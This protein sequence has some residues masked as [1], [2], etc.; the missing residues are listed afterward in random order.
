[1]WSSWAKQGQIETWC[2]LSVGAFCP[3][4]R[5]WKCLMFSGRS[6]KCCWLFPHLTVCSHTRPN[7][8]S[9]TTA[10]LFCSQ[11]P[12]LLSQPPLFFFLRVPKASLGG[13]GISSSIPQVSVPPPLP[14][15]SHT[16]CFL[17]APLFLSADSS[18]SCG[19]SCPRCTP[20]RHT[21]MAVCWQCVL[22]MNQ[23]RMF[24]SLVPPAHLLGCGCFSCLPL[25][26]LAFIY[27]LSARLSL[28]DRQS[29]PPILPRVVF[30]ASFILHPTSILI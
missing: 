23:S 1:M 9:V 17:P 11:P 30:Q 20:L 21:I 25:C 16:P 5:D 3:W 28:R 6:E 19:S 10:C 2:V 22:C 14:P 26:V 8:F 7:C 12:F 15:F 24:Q 4:S 18:T 27:L 13:T 29:P